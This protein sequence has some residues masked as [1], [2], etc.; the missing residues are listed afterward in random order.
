[1]VLYHLK[2]CVLV[3]CIL[4]STINTV[5]GFEEKE[6]NE[7]SSIIYH[8]R[9]LPSSDPNGPYRGGLDDPTDLNYLTSAVIALIN[10]AIMLYKN[11]PMEYIDDLK[12]SLENGNYFNVTMDLSGLTSYAIIMVSLL[13]FTLE[14]FDILD[15]DR[16]GC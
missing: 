7:V 14:A 10:L 12:E 6:T 16:D 2:V 3:S 9:N 8:G 1:M 5:I 4:L 13:I 11:T 15:C